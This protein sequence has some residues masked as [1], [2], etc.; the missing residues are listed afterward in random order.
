MFCRN[1]PRDFRTLLLLAGL[2]L[3]VVV[4]PSAQGQQIDQ[5][6]SMDRY[7]FLPRLPEGNENPPPLPE[8]QTEVAGSE[9]V[10]VEELRGIVILDNPQKVVEGKLDV[11]GIHVHADSSLDLARTNGFHRLVLAARC[12]VR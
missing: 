11:T 6:Q 1:A 5:W 8:T 9:K 4:A 2:L 7:R 12:Q 3:V 10:L